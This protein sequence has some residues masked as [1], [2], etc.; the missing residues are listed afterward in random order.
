[1]VLDATASFSQTAHDAAVLRMLQLGVV[2]TTWLSL[3]AELQKSYQNLETLPVYGSLAPQVPPMKMLM[4][5]VTAAQQ[6]V[7][8][9]S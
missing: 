8:A 5:T 9:Q 7:T 2:P 3:A 6:S 4:A 1:V